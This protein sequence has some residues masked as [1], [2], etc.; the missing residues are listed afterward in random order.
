MMF[1]ILTRTLE[2]C[3]A[4]FHHWCLKC[5]IFIQ[6]KVVLILQAKAD[7]IDSLDKYKGKCKPTF[8]CYAVR[9]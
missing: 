4:M 7:T 5:N 8:L 2:M 9:L 1:C 6:A 3:I